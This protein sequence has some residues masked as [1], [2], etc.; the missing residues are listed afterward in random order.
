[1][2]STVLRGSDGLVT[3]DGNGTIIG[4]TPSSVALARSVG[5][6]L[7]QGTNGTSGAIES[8]YSATSP[9]RAGSFF[10][11]AFGN[12][13]L[14][15]Q[16]QTCDPGHPPFE[17]RWKTMLPGT[18]IVYGFSNAPEWNAARQMAVDAAF[19]MWKNANIA[20]TLNTRFLNDQSVAVDQ[21][22]LHIT[23]LPKVFDAQLIRR[24]AMITRLS[25]LGPSGIVTKALVEIGLED[26]SP[27]ENPITDLMFTKIMLHEVG[28]AMGLGHNGGYPSPLW[29]PYGFN[30][31][32]VM[33]SP[34]GY[35]DSAGWM[36]T[37]VT[38]CDAAKA[39]AAAQ[40][41][42]P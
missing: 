40:R 1:M 32:S 31:S 9:I 36:S 10:S 28:H 16:P 18:E 6:G 14:N 26:F 25:P 29:H 21:R 39:R 5:P 37:V 8:V 3:L 24:S 33:N 17:T 13:F 4:T 23:V 19:A 35:S 2:L 22:P 34:G 12:Q 27:G 41:R 20:S 42:W 7:Y 11:W 30:G 15:R 38:P